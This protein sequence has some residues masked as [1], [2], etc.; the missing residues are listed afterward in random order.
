MNAVAPNLSALI[1]DI[2][3]S[4]LIIFVSINVGF[5]VNI[6]EYIKI[7]DEYLDE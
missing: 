6:L 2:V 1:G 5:I 3:G 7:I 4:K